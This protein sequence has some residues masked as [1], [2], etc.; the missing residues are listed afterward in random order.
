MTLA[1]SLVS[2][3][4]YAVI[5]KRQLSKHSKIY[6]LHLN[7]PSRS[8]IGHVCLNDDK[9]TIRQTRKLSSNG[10]GLMIYLP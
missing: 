1:V 7:E 5:V 9:Y 2:V 10:R 3:C 6:L 4:L 8:D